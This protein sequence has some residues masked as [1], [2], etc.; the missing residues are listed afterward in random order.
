MTDNQTIKDRVILFLKAQNLPKAR[1]EKA[2][3]LSN[4]YVNSMKD[5]FGVQKLE[6]VLNTYPQLS[7]TWLLTGEGE[8]LTPHAVTAT[9]HSA[10]S[11]NGNATAGDSENVARLIV[12]LS[13]QREAYT[14]QIDRLIGL[15]ERG[16]GASLT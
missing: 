14:R 15:L 4:G 9:D 8:M 10:A 5:G 6:Q 3:G 7:R 13:A 1:F 16:Q 2:C 11:V 12:E